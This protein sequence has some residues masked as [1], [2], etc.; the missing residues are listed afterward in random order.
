MKI[1]FRVLHYRLFF[2][3]IEGARDVGCDNH[4]GSINLHSAKISRNLSE[5]CA[6]RANRLIFTEQHKNMNFSI[7]VRLIPKNPT[8]IRDYLKLL[9]SLN[10]TEVFIKTNP[11]PNHIWHPGAEMGNKLMSKLPRNE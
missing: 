9:N 7:T 11:I 10:L 1:Y 4:F 3:V 5:F 6:S 2:T 8:W